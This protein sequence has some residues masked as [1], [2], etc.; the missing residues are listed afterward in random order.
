MEALGASGQF[1]F[2]IIE[3]AAG[4]V[5][6]LE[7]NPRTHSAVTL[8]HGHPG[9]TAAYLED[10]S[11]VIR[12]L[13]SAR[14]TY[15]P[16]HELWRA[17]SDPQTLPECVRTVARGR[18]ALWDPTDPLPFLLV[19]HLQIPLLLLRNLVR[20]KPWIRIDFNIGKIV[21]PAGD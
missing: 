16:Y 3:S 9:V 20:R 8:F 10:G 13:P 2:D 1:S 18:D 4:Q 6:G 19:H 5:V 7:C 11:R 15:W 14:P 17:L 12:P 21:E